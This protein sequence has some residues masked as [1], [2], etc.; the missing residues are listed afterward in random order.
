MRTYIYLCLLLF[1][2]NVSAQ[3]FVGS[4]YSIIGGDIN[5][6]KLLATMDAYSDALMKVGGNLDSQVEIKDDLIK[7]NAFKITLTNSSVQVLKKDCQIQKESFH[8]L[9]TLHLSPKNHPKKIESPVVSECDSKEALQFCFV[10]NKKVI[11]SA[12]NIIQT[13]LTGE[14]RVLWRALGINR[15]LKTMPFRVIGLAQNEE[16]SYQSGM[17]QLR[18][19]ARFDGQDLYESYLAFISYREIS[20]KAELISKRQLLYLTF[21]GGEYLCSSDEC[22]IFL[23]KIFN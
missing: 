12:E 5:L 13:H 6:S 8:C 22:M 23:P 14:L 3:I 1:S 2:Q 16:A 11:R 9:I 20:I 19:L 18:R 10:I 17:L 4:G 15:I 7:S 21:F